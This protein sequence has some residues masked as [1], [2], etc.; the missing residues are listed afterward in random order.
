MR[1]QRR[2]EALKRWPKVL[3][4]NAPC[5][6]EV[7]RKTVQDNVRDAGA[8]E[9]R[10]LLKGRRVPG[11]VRIRRVGGESRGND[12]LLNSARSASVIAARFMAAFLRFLISSC[13]RRSAAI[14]AFVFSLACAA[15]RFAACA[16]SA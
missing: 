3:A 5:V 10:R 1:L 11:R 4:D 2:D 16:L 7:P 13:S 8:V 6:R 12:D 14:C 9:S 15:S